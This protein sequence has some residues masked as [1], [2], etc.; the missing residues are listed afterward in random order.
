[1]SR[2]SH[3][4]CLELVVFA[5]F[6]TIGQSFDWRE[7]IG[8]QERL[9]GRSSHNGEISVMSRDSS[10]GNLSVC[11]SWHGRA[12]TCLQRYSLKWR[13][14][15]ATVPNCWIKSLLS[16]DFHTKRILVAFITLRLNHWWQMHYF[17]D[18]FHTFLDQCIIIF[19]A[20]NRTVTSLPVFILNILNCVPKTNEVD[21][22]CI[23][24]FCFWLGFHVFYFDILPCFLFLPCAPLVCV[25]CSHWL[26][27]HSTVSCHVMKL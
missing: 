4:Y 24:G 2:A 8:L 14:G 23:L 3:L 17:V 22:R 20:V 11:R 13:Y 7:P 10:I 5:C 9:K 15:D 27:G 12:Y 25:S 6:A 16:F 21:V 18:F 26:I 19:L 1:M